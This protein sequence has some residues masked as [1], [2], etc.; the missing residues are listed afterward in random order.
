[1]IG[2]NEAIT[3]AK[4]EAKK[5]REGCKLTAETNS[6][7]VFIPTTIDGEEKYNSSSY[8][9]DKKSGKVSEFHILDFMERDERTIKEY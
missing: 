3:I 1:M 7:Y 2:L 5:N 4:N 6:F 9:V 8:V